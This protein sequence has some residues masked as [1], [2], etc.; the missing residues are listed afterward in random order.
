MTRNVVLIVLDTVRK[1]L[2]DKYAP[3][4]RA[5]ADCEASRCYT[6]SNWTVP[7]HAS[8]L[9]GTLPHEHEV[10]ACTPIFSNIS[11]HDTFLSE[12]SDHRTVAVN[13]NFTLNTKD[14]FRNFFD[15]YEK[16]D[17]TQ[18]GFLDGGLDLT[19]FAAQHEGNS[20]SKY[21][22][23]LWKAVE[24]DDP[25]ASI[26]NGTA[27]KLYNTTNWLPNVPRIADYGTKNVIESSKKVLDTDEPVFLYANFMEAHM[28]HRSV[29]EYDQSLYSVPHFW[30]TYNIDNWDI[31]TESDP[32]KYTK[33]F[34]RLRELYTAS[35]DYLDRQ[36]LEL[37]KWVEDTTTRETTVIVTSDHG[38]NL[39]YE[40]EDYLVGHAGSGLSEALLHVPLLVFNPPADA[41]LGNESHFISQ[42]DIGR[43]CQGFADGES[44]NVARKTVPAER[45]C[46][47]GRDSLSQNLDN[48]EYWDR[49]ERC[50]YRGNTKIVWDSL[51][52]VRE[53]TVGVET[54]YE[55]HTKDDPGLRDTDLFSISLEDYKRRVDEYCGRNVIRETENVDEAVK[56]RLKE[57]GYG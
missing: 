12:L 17:F 33:Y 55:Q 14:G 48:F 23:F 24:N 13:S 29:K 52:R 3:R 25:L 41:N 11:Y 27:V 39:G 45:I 21:L 6:A 20:I 4:L 56:Q 16:I 1:D 49:A 37:I 18:F 50:V 53:F 8:M 9:T 46:L 10:H 26:I 47:P 35:I 44:P 28:P 19:S 34:E 36:V 51:G 40:Y 31:N 2:F 38:E 5:A 7:S 32:T 22:Y 15:N 43:L 54:S 42:L 30:S 57:L